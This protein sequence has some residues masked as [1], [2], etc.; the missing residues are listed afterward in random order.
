MSTIPLSALVLGDSPDSFWF[1]DKAST[2]AENVDWTYDMILWISLVF[3]VGIVF[4]LVWFS[5]RYLKGKGEKAESQKSHNTPLELAWSILPSFLLVWMF[6]QGSLSFLDMRTPPEGAFEVQVEAFTWNWLM[7]YG[8]GTKHPELHILVDE[9]TKLTMRSNDMIHSLFIPAFRAKK[10]IVPGRYNEMWFQ[11]TMA[12]EKVSDEELAAAEEEVGD[13]TWDYDAYQF[14]PDG[15]RFYDLYCAEYCG[16]DHSTMQTVV[17]VHETREDLDAWIEEKSARGDIAPEVWGKQ[18]YEQR[19]CMGCHSTD[20]KKRTGPSFENVYGSLRPL[21]AGGEVV[22]DENYVRESILNPQ[23]KVTAG[24]PPVMPSFRGQLSD[25]DIDSIIAYL[26]TLSE[27]S[28]TESEEDGV[29][30]ETAEEPSEESEEPAE[31]E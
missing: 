25:D 22:A 16:T 24:F 21:T 18:L 10:D 23:A 4:C 1:P 26:K 12:S 9:P 20:G 31:A 17:V 28:E 13:G 2:F 7:D 5:I 8:R 3:F 15:Y 6:V 29:E 14:T 11:A 30:E 19:G 27:N